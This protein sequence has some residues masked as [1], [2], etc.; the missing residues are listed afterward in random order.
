MGGKIVNIDEILE[1]KSNKANNEVNNGIYVKHNNWHVLQKLLRFIQ[2]T[3]L[4]DPRKRVTALEEISDFRSVFFNDAYPSF[5]RALVKRGHGVI[6]ESITS[7]YLDV[8]KREVA[9]RIRRM[10]SFREEAK[11]DYL[12]LEVSAADLGGSSK[13]LERWRKRI[14][15]ELMT[16]PNFEKDADFVERKHNEE[17]FECLT[18]GDVGDDSDYSFG[19]FSSSFE[20]DES[21]HDE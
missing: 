17:M 10:Y 16:K 9:D 18:E 8:R 12:G 11:I 14:Y 1:K 21:D 4:I 6:T 13:L 7:S 3:T 20:D 15:L 2:K 19:T 5:Q